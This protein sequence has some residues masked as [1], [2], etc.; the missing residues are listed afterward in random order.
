MPPRTLNL[1]VSCAQNRVIGRDGRLPWRIRE[2]WR[3]FLE[4]T[5]GATVVLGRVCFETWPGARREG[6]T[7]VVVTSHP[8]GPT[9]RAVAAPSLPAALRIAEALGAETYLCGGQRIYEEALRLPRPL[10]LHLTEVRAVVSG[11]RF[12]P[13]WRGRNWRELARRTGADADYRYSFLT[14]EC[15]AA[16]G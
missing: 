9:P 12:F 8:P 6:R 13:E 15:P 4:R 2:D 10:R 14:L 5:R 3:F 16:R 11:D 7:A 1:I